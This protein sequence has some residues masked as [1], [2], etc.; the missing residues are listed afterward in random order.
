MPK[1][2]F[3]KKF[4]RHANHPRSHNKIP[5]KKRSSVGFIP[6]IL[7][8]TALC[9]GLTAIRF[10]LL[11]KWEF[12]VAALIIAAILD[13]LDG[14]VARLL[15]HTSNFGA[16]LDSLADFLGFGVTPALLLYIHSLHQWQGLGWAICLFYVICGALRLARFNTMR[17]EN[18][19][20]TA[21]FFIGVPI[22][23]A[24]CLTMLP[25]LIDFVCEKQYMALPEILA[26]FLITFGLLMISRLPTFSFKKLKVSHR[27][28]IPIL[29]GVALLGVSIVNAPWPT[30]IV[31]EII[32]ILLLPFG[33]IQAAKLLKNQQSLEK[34]TESSKD[35]SL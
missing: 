21:N 30:L 31:L 4:H 26:S 10:G 13:A 2:L 6:N 32:Y 20:L 7:T 5:F 24:A 8:V 22:P 3:T 17:S 1:L 27:L 9:T 19:A 16:E 14:R 34:N 15:G 11:H 35:K 33:A 29:I 23:A 28:M 25:L 18:T 12:A